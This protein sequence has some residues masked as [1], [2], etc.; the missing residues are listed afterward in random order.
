MPEKYA[1]SQIK[2]INHIVMHNQ[3]AFQTTTKNFILKNE[4]YTS[5]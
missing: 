5:F 1:E 2:A 3:H 4:V